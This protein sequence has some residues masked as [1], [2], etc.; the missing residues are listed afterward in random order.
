[1]RQSTAILFGLLLILVGSSWSQVP[2]PAPVETSRVQVGGYLAADY[3]KSEEEGLFPKGTFQN[4]LVGFT[5]TGHLAPQITFQTEASFY[6]GNS[7]DIHQAWIGLQASQYL[8][9][10]AGLYVVPFGQFNE[11]NLPHQ[12]D[13]INFPLSIEYLF[14]NTWRDIGVMA[15]GNISGLLYTAY[16][17]NGLYEESS[18]DSGQQFRDNNR[19]KAWGGRLEVTL[20]QGF[21]LGYSYYKGK[22]DDADSRNQIMQAAT[23]AWMTADFYVKAEYNHA[24]L[25]TPD[26]FDDGT[27]W[28]Y[29][30]QTVMIWKGFRPVVSYQVLNYDDSF[31]GPGFAGPGQP[32]LGISEEKT[33]WALGAVVALAQNAY[34][35]FE[36]DFNREKNLEIKNDTYLI[37]V[38]VGF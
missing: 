14:P 8:N 29:Y 2:Y 27:A 23:A 4:P 28:G 7:F 17:G 38:T 32:G 10:K 21:S 3:A 19:N 20:D 35:K 37:Q 36:Y 12:T 22:Y 15:S 9:V 34:L 5:L 26:E 33:R 25:E 16:L 24:K 18:L 1:M 30:I 13:T 6:D 31:H 11:N